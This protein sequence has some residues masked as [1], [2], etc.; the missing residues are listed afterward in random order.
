MLDR[1][2]NLET[3]GRT[4]AFGAPRNCRGDRAFAVAT[5]TGI[6][7]L[8]WRPV[9]TPRPGP[10]IEDD[11][12]GRRRLLRSPSEC[13]L[14]GDRPRSLSIPPRSDRRA[15]G[16]AGSFL[17]HPVIRRA[18]IVKLA[19][20]MG[21]GEGGGCPVGH[22]SGLGLVPGRR[23]RRDR[24]RGNRPGV[25]LTSVEAFLSGCRIARRVKDTLLH[26]TAVEA[27][28]EAFLSRARYERREEEGP[29]GYHNGYRALA[30]VEKAD[31][32]TVECSARS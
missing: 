15:G 7:H 16:F 4:R 1:S 19:P 22:G 2:A 27:E 20:T 6:L 23:R 26:Q 32:G 3:S 12:A 11:Q 17:T 25:H 28:V 18:A 24:W 21:D 13:D 5:V 9:Q 14:E 30:A 29:A 31:D 10:R 8:R